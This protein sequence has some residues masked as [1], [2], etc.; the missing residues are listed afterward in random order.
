V[1]HCDSLKRQLIYLQYEKELTSVT[2]KKQTKEKPEER[3]NEK[4]NGEEAFS[5]HAKL[6][7]KHFSSTPVCEER[8]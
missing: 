8:G 1:L 5:S 3:S 7:K 6:N 4:A 2:Y